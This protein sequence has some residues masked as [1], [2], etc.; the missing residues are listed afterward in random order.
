MANYV[1]DASVVIEYLVTD[2]FTPN[3]MAFFAQVT[4][5]DQL[6]VPEFCLMECT[7]V[8]WKQVRFNNMPLADA[9]NLVKDLRTLKL[10]RTPM[11][12]QLERALEIGL[13]NA[14]AIYDS[15]YIALALHYSYPLITI[16]DRQSKAAAAEGVTL[17]PIMDFK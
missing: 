17:K 16:D 7:N 1:V 6:V 12:R 3:A 15:G 8:I 9:R 2:Q 11:K 10:R 4:D 5:S 14:L 13:N